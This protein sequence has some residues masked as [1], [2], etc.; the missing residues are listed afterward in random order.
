M[1]KPPITLREEVIFGGENDGLVAENGVTLTNDVYSELMMIP[2][3]QEGTMVSQP[4]KT[5]N[6]PKRD[7]SFIVWLLVWIRPSLVFY[8]PCQIF[9]W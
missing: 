5:L 1:G 6:K 2:R 4:M 3:H 7:I 9:L 8:R